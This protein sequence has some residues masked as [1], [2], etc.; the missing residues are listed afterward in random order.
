MLGIAFKKRSLLITYNKIA[1]TARTEN[2][3][4]CFQKEVF[5]YY[6][7]SQPHCGGIR[8]GWELL[9][10]R[11]LC[12]LLTIDYSHSSVYQHL[13]SQLD[14]LFSNKNWE[15]GLNDSSF[16]LS[17]Q[18]VIV[19]IYRPQTLLCSDSFLMQALLSYH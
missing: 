8:H 3:G 17:I 14:K 13:L 15:K 5:A 7:Q 11:G 18:F 6:L 10:K 4:N 12:L 16:F 2:V 1:D 19:W 9:S